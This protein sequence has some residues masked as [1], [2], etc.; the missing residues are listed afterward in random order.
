MRLGPRSLA[1]LF[2]A[3]CLLLVSPETT[4]LADD[5][6][7]EI[8]PFAGYRTGGTFDLEG[9]AG[10]YRI[11]DSEAYGVLFNLRQTGNTQWEVLYSQQ[12]TT[13]RLRDSTT[14]APSVDTDIQV[15]QIGGTYQ[16][17]GETARPYLALT[18]GGTHIKATA[19]GSQSDT[20]FSGSLGVG[21]N[22][23]PN[24]RLGI[25]LEAR[26]YATLMDSSTDLFCSTGPD[27]NICAVRIEGNLLS[28]VEAFAGLVFRF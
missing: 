12:Q 23:L 10:S 17:S 4:A 20:F 5:L 8:T 13:A 1:L 11:D 15:L 24:K 27:A 7:V 19:N 18:L 16:G 2:L 28:Q 25:R 6:N 22:L 9:I 26:V 14:G 3:T 21:L